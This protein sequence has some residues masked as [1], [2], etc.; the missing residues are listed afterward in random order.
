MND[1]SREN[2]KW[3]YEC[4]DFITAVHSLIVVCSCFWSHHNYFLF[5]HLQGV[6]D[7]FTKH[8]AVGNPWMLIRLPMVYAA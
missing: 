2:I 6:K 8:C 7:G 5:H 3:G 4:D 1:S